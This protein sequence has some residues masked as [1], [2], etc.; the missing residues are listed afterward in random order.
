[1]LNIFLLLFCYQIKFRGEPKVGNNICVVNIVGWKIII[2]FK[3]L[4]YNANCY[5]STSI[6]CSWIY[7]KSYSLP[8]LQYL[9][10][11]TTMLIII[12]KYLFIFCIDFDSFF[13]KFHEW[14]LL[15]H[16]EKI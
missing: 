12:F 16:Q 10:I 2:S 7:S 3:H 13:K 8:L 6:F 14:L 15:G 1:V 9:K 4:K 11:I 5:L